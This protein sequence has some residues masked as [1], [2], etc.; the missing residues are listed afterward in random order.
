M[1]HINSLK[2]KDFVSIPIKLTIQGNEEVNQPAWMEKTI[3]NAKLCPDGTHIRLYFDS[4]HFIAVP[5]HSEI[6]KTSHMWSA[7][8]KETSLRYLIKK[9]GDGCHD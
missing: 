9:I 2:L 6:T 7:F 1:K 5:K 3:Q 4:F 8:D